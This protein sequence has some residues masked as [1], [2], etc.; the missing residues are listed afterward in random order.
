MNR[1]FLW[2]CH[3]YWL[4]DCSAIK[5][6]LEYDGSISMICR[7][8]QELLGYQ[9]TVVH[10]C[11]R[12]MADVDALTR[13][14]GPLI[15][16][17]CCIAGILHK[18]DI[19]ARPLAYESAS[20]HDSPTARLTPPSTLHVTAPTLTSTYLTSTHCC[21][22]PPIA[23]QPSLTISSSPILFVAAS[24]IYVPRSPSDGAATKMKISTVAS[25]LQSEWWCIDDYFGSLLH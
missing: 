1:K 17:H 10:R 8:A 24:K 22:T 18:T 7:W 13:R 11:N 20:F 21:N 12:M 15:A 16:T 14:F 3:F 19:T 4:C 5:E 23:L 9:F 2:G 6:V 25:S